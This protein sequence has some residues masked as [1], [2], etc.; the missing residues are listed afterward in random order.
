MFNDFL[1]VIF[2][3][4]FILGE[5][6]TH[7]CPAGL[8][9]APHLWPF[10]T[11]S[12]SSSSSSSSCS[13]DI[14]WEPREQARF[15]SS[16]SI[17]VSLMNKKER[18]QRNHVSRGSVRGANKCVKR[19][20]LR[21]RGNYSFV[22]L[23]GDCS[24][25]SHLCCKVSRVR[26]FSSISLGLSPSV[27]STRLQSKSA[28]AGISPTD[29]KS[30]CFLGEDGGLC[31]MQLSGGRGKGL[32]QRTCSDGWS[33]RTRCQDWWL[34]EQLTSP[35]GASPL[36]DGGGWKCQST[37]AGSPFCNTGQGGQRAKE[38]GKNLNSD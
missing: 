9:Q 8:M 27:S 28:Q 32:P 36:H 5:E 19:K 29:L 35:G 37:P 16:S 24:F 17:A 34:S 38:E 18:M 15:S 21:Q 33:C 7:H 14:C 2:T 13:T 25:R 26:S 23:M 31:V 3:F 6:W 30:Q 11:P 4:Y 1:F 12:C 20:Q 22:I 10:L